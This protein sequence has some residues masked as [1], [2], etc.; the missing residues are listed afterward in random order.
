MGCEQREGALEICEALPASPKHEEGTAAYE[1]KQHKTR[2]PGFFPRGI[3]K[4]LI[5][6]ECQFVQDTCI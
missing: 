3:V 5:G 4:W 2:Q 6:R 1:K